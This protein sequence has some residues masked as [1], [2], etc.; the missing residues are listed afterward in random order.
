MAQL[1]VW[2]EYLRD[3][4]LTAVS[5]AA[6]LVVFYYLL[7]RKSRVTREADARL[8]ELRK[9]RGDYYNSQRPLR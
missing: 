3:H 7:N 9:D 1:W 2:I 4:P 5:G 6:A 8:G